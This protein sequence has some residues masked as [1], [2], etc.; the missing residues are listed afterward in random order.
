MI[1]RDERAGQFAGHHQL[2]LESRRRLTANPQPARKPSAIPYPYRIT[3][4]TLPLNH[5]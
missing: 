5:E 2:I 3:P 1:F 4:R